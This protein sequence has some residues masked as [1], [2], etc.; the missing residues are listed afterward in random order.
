MNML[1]AKKFKA[2]I[3]SWKSFEK[4]LWSDKNLGKAICRHEY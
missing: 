1:F 3:K 4:S 2:S